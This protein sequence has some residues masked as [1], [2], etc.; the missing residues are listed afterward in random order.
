MFQNYMD[1]P[2]DGC[3][4]LFTIGRKSRMIAAINASRPSLLSSSCGGGLTPTPEIC[5]NGIDD[6]VGRIDC[7]DGDCATASNCNLS[8]QRDVLL[9]LA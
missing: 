8:H 9:Q 4:N 1:Y 2:N 3:M 6:G 5:N 7:A